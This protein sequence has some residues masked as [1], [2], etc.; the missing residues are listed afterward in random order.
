[1]WK[2]K[3]NSHFDHLVVTASSDT[4]VNLWD[5]SDISSSAENVDP[6]AISKKPEESLLL[7]SYEDHDESVYSVAW[8]AGDAFTFASL[9]Y[10]QNSRVVVSHFCISFIPSCLV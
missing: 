5:L 3:F 10:D 6:V 8:S 4:L 9:S 1:M 2:V 7:K